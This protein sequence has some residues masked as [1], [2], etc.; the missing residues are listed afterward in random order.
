M[1]L[2]H[3]L[4][5]F[6]LAGIF[7]YAG[8]I[9]YLHPDVF[10][11]DIEG[12]RLLPYPLA[13]VLAFYLP[14]VEIICGVLLLF[15]GIYRRSAAVILIVLML[16][17]MIAILSAWIRGLDISCGCFGAAKNSTNYP[18]LIIRDLVIFVGLAVVACCRPGMGTL[19]Q[20]RRL[21]ARL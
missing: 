2:L 3:L 4:V 20:A 8:L 21:V 6:V 17:F 15:S 18:L 16:L 7:I 14:P 13:W 9:K 1:K 10:L 12:Y 19:P 5:R 11:V